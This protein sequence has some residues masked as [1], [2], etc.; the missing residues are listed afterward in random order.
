MGNSKGREGGGEGGIVLH[1]MFGT[2]EEM[3]LL[4]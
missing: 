1:Y 2:E 4:L 3:K